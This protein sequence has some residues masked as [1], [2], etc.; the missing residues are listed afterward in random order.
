MLTITDANGRKANQL[1]GML[2]VQATNE[3]V[4]GIDKVILPNLGM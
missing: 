4:Y 3:V 1:P 2:N